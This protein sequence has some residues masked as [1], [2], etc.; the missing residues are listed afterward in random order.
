VKVELFT[1]IFFV[2][3]KL[4]TVSGGEWFQGLSLPPMNNFGGTIRV[5]FWALMVRFSP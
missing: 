3:A 1:V 5:R 4:F 2:G